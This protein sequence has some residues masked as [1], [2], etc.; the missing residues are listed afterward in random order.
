MTPA[1]TKNGY[2]IAGDDFAHNQY[3]RP[4]DKALAYR[5]DLD[6]ITAALHLD[7]QWYYVTI[8]L[9]GTDTGKQTLDANYGV[10]LDVNI[11]GRG[12]Y[13]IWAQ[14]PFTTTWSRENVTVYGTTTNLVGGPTPLLSDAPW[15]GKTYDKILFDA[16]T[17]PE[18]NAAWVRVAP[19]DPKTLQIAFSPDIIQKPVR[20]LWGAWADDGIKDPAK[21]DYN[22]LF[23]KKEAGSPYKWDP[24]Y[25]P[26][27]LFAVD[28]T[29][30]APY[31][32]KPNG[33]LPGLCEL[34]PT[35]GPQ[36]KP[37]PTATRT[38]APPG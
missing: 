22:D 4:L 2:A 38:Q 18:V 3:E 30:R 8:T 7:S 27:A 28:N 32:F 15:T 5:P 34:Q 17:T 20:F 1:N 16:K 14:P 23:T 11:D 26:K 13:V 12:D 6:I 21:F 33:S 35:P 9:N 31:G 37:G 29:C 10:E 25:P 36:Q 24:D 19:E